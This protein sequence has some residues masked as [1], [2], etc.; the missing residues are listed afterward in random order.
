MEKIRSF[1]LNIEE[2]LASFNIVSLF[3]E[4]LV[5]L[6]LEVTE[7]RLCNDFILNDKTELSV[8]NIL[9]L[10]LCLEVTNITFQG[11]FYHQIYGTV[12]GSLVLMIVA[13]MVMETIEEKA[14]IIF[15][16]TTQ[17]WAQ[18]IDDTSAIFLKK[19]LEQI[20]DHLNL[21]E[22]TIKIYSCRRRKRKDFSS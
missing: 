12:M 22:L 16:H 8:S 9:V 10:K 17:F 6:V 14:L 11:Q 2:C 7:Q 3:T 15:S 18:Y 5:D 20:F 1:K 4:V 21:V 13:N 19:Y